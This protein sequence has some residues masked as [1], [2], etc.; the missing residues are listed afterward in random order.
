V[1]SAK[2]TTNTKAYTATGSTITIDKS[3]LEAGTHKY[4]LKAGDKTSKV[5]RLNV[6][7]TTLTTYPNPAGP[8]EQA[9][10]EF[11][12][13]QATDVTVSLYNTL[14][15]RVRV[16]HRGTVDAGESIRT[17]IDAQSLS[18]GVYFVRMRGDGVRATTRMTIVK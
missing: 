2:A 3:K 6:K 11:V 5:E 9:T 1:S 12:T 7:G 8:G 15:Q 4:R 10:V 16:L 18:S 13:E 17:P 14:G